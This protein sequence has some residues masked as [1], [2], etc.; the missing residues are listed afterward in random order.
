MDNWPRYTQNWIY[1]PPSVGD[2]DG[3][4]SLDVAIGDQILSGVPTDYVYAWDISGTALDGF[5]I[6]PIWAVNSQI[7]LADLDGDAMLE[8]MFDDNTGEG[9]FNGYNH[10]GTM[11]DGWPLEVEGSTFFQNPFVFDIEGNGTLNITGSSYDS[12]MGETRVYLWETGVA[13]DDAMAVLPIL[14]YNVRHTGVY[15]EKGNPVVNLGEIVKSS[16][17][18][19]KYRPNPCANETRI[20]FDTNDCRGEIRIYNSGG[21]LVK[22]VLPDRIPAASG[23]IILSTQDLQPGVYMIKIEGMAACSKLVVTK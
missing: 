10:D 23:G 11:M 2:I 16:S 17:Q 15:G 22:T 19:I 8:L 3:N 5:P 18:M 1:G 7:I 12:N 21:R 20:Y 6:G 9:I 14:Q 13:F 4:G